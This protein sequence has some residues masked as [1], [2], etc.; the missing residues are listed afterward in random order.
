MRG[1]VLGLMATFGGVLLFSAPELA[2][3]W[4]AGCGA[5]AGGPAALLA[6]AEA[7]LTPGRLVA[8]K[9]IGA[10]LCNWVMTSWYY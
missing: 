4:A 5:A 2:L 6:G 8:L 9:V 3:K 7:A 1:A 10:A